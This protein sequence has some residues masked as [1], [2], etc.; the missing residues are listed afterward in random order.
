MHSVVVGGGPAGIYSALVLSRTSKVSLIEMEER[1]GGTCVL[2]GCIPTKSMLNPLILSLK[3]YKDLGKKFEISFDELREKSRKVIDRISKGIQYV[4]EDNGV[5]IIRGKATI[6]EN[7]NAVNVGSQKIQADRIIIA[8]GTRREREEWLNYTEDLPN[9]SSNFERVVVLGGDVGGVEMAWL[10]KN[11]GKEVYLVEK[12]SSLLHY[13]DKDL[14]D[15]VTN[16]FRKIGIKLFL[17]TEIS[18]ISRNSVI[19]RTGEI[20][21]GDMVFLTYGRKTNIEGFEKLSKDG[22]YVSVNEYLQTSIKN[23]YAAGDIIGTHTAHE[24]IYA[25]VIAGINASGGDEKFNRENIPKVIYTHPQIAYVGRPEGKCV[26]I[27]TISLTRSNIDR[28]TEGF[29]KL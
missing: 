9:L 23:V 15:A 27:Q 28:E 11:L 13:L 19:T 21:S 3:L 4:L 14:R 6:V 5:E 18:K 2:Y 16:Y 24:A 7:G 25:G 8:T 12:Q 17:N 22:K 26:K 10:M 20:I 1:L 29:F